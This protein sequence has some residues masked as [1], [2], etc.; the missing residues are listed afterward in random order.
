MVRRAELTPECTIPT[1]HNTEILLSITIEQLI[2]YGQKLIQIPERD[3]DISS[4]WTGKARLR[5]FFPAGNKKVDRKYLPYVSIFIPTKDQP[6]ANTPLRFRLPD[7]SIAPLIKGVDLGV[8]SQGAIVR[9][10]PY[11]EET[12]VKLTEFEAKECVKELVNLL[13]LNPP[14]F[15][16]QKQIYSPAIAIGKE[17]NCEWKDSHLEKIP[18]PLAGY[19]LAKLG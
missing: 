7:S 15:V 4:N 3:S 19:L 10:A 16:L 8:D 5:V 6:V 11:R 12:Q 9:P 13:F 2:G 17:V 14:F 18:V 1:D